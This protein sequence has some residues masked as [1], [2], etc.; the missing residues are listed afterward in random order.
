LNFLGKSSQKGASAQKIKNIWR[1][2]RWFWAL[3]RFGQSAQGR[4]FTFSERKV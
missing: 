2:R 1:Q 3:K 4:E